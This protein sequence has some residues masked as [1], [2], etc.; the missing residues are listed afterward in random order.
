MGVT[1]SASSSG[2]AGSFARLIPL[3]VVRGKSCQSPD[4]K[5]GVQDRGEG[6]T[7]GVRSHCRMGPWPAKQQDAAKDGS[8]C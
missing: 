3:H 1:K 4:T 2:M 6:R 7:Q 8:L 5:E